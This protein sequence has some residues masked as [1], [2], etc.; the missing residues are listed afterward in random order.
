MLKGSPIRINILFSNKSPAQKRTNCS[1]G[2]K[3]NASIKNKNAAIKS[4]PPRILTKT[5]RKL[6]FMS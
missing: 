4:I 5:I 2:C 1:Q 3:L 6:N